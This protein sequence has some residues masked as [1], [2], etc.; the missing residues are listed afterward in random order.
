MNY[1]ATTRRA[2]VMFELTGHQPGHEL[3]MVL[4]SCHQAMDRSSPFAEISILPGVEFGN[5]N[6][7]WL[8]RIP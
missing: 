2:A 1:P 4:D 7:Q 5:R 6:I 8:V 3:Q